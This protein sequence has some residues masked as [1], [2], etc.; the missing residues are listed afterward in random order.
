[1]V[2][3]A[4]RKTRRLKT[5]FKFHDI[6]ILIITG[7]VDSPGRVWCGGGGGGGGYGNKMGKIR[8]NSRNYVM[9]NKHHR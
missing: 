1:M 8:D 7:N 9:I 4:N 2:H 6:L 3:A 5:N